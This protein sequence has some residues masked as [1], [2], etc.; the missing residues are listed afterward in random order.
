MFTLIPFIVVVAIGAGV[1]VWQR[2][3]G[4]AA[5]AGEWRRAT[6]EAPPEAPGKPVKAASLSM[7]PG[8]GTLAADLSRWVGAG[9]LSADQADAIAGFER[10]ATTGR[11]PAGGERRVSLLAEALGYVGVVLAAAGAAV[12]LAQGWE[13][14]PAWARLAIPAVA[15]G[16]LLLGGI[17]L[18]RQ[19]E[20]A[21]RRLMSVLWMLS[22]G[23]TAWTLAVLGADVLELDPE[24][25]ALL[26]SA[27]CAAAA[28][29]LWL[30][31]RRGL[32]QAA[33]LAS[34]HALV[35]SGLICLPGE[36][37]PLWWF[38]AAVWA[39]GV[40]W[41]ALGWRNAIAPGW[42]AVAF[43]CLGAVVGPSIG[44][45]AYE[46]LLAPA[47]AT[48]AF[49]MAVSVPTRQTPLLALGTL[50]AFGYI[51]WAVVHYF[52]NSLGVPVALVIVGAVFLV[53]AVL[54][55]ALATRGRG[56]AGAPSE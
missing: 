38:A 8:F 28:A 49:L 31:R 1:F 52:E 2:R 22:I 36:D 21:F 27:G 43:G 41:A 16:L 37:P 34:L 29:G 35:V 24:P 17:L 23:G 6:G 56:K 50:G 55:G 53:L 46:W 26:T 15:T 32:Q 19:D 5:G 30:L 42:L 14:L 47:L 11:G 54:A 45:G 7:G 4:R 51:T 12:G 39:L 10:A 48:T 44:L 33:L 9:L 3:R 40:A 13:D 18:R 20:P 25:I